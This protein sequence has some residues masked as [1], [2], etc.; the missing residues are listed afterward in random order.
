MEISDPESGRAKRGVG[1]LFERA[2]GHALLAV[3]TAEEESAR[4]VARFAE[5]AGWGQEEVKRQVRDF[6]EQLTSQRRG[7]EREMEE[8]AKR[9]LLALRVPRREELEQI[10]ARLDRIAHRLDALS[11]ESR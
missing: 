3:S 10:G 11:K 4:M 7:I 1:E 6:T 8:G 9:A 2:W 5:V